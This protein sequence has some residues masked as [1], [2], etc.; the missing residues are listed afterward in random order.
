[1]EKIS[2]TT[3]RVEEMICIWGTC[4]KCSIVIDGRGYHRVITNDIF[5][6]EPY[7]CDECDGHGSKEEDC[8]ECNGY[9]TVDKRCEKCHGTK[10]LA[11]ENSE[12]KFIKREMQLEKR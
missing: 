10:V 12:R 7:E 11:D 5:A 4:S 2:K 8:P 1:M 6:L 9:G 3:V